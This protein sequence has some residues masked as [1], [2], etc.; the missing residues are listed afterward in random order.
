MAVKIQWFVQYIYLFILG[1]VCSTWS[2][3]LEIHPGL[4]SF[5]ATA[6]WYPTVWT[7]RSWFVQSPVHGCLGCFRFGTV[8]DGAAVNICG[9]MR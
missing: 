9:F 4:G 3:G 2:G 5:I 7:R 8:T 6:E 1:L